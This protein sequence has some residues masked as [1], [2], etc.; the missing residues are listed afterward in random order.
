MLFR[1]NALSRFSYCQSGLVLGTPVRRYHPSRRVG[2]H[3][4]S[5]LEPLV[6]AT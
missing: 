2:E 1:P 4:T 6:I 3:T 5:F